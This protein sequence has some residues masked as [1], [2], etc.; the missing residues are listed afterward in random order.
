[1]QERK[2]HLFPPQIRHFTGRNK[3]LS[4]LQKHFCKDVGRPIIVAVCR[5]PG[6]GKT[7]IVLQYVNAHAHEYGL[8]WW[9]HAETEAQL[10]QG[11]FELAKAVGDYTGSIEHVSVA[12]WKHLSERRDWLLIFDNGPSRKAVIP[13]FVPEMIRHGHILITSR[14]AGL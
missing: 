12:A 6:V 7:Q 8:V 9:F 5:L 2:I 10:L 14:H 3:L 1:M 4:V 13:K 11:F